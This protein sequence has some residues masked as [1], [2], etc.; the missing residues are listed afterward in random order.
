[1]K[2]PVF[3]TIAAT[4]SLIW[5]QKRDFALLSLPIIIVFSIIG[6]VTNATTWARLGNPASL[7]EYIDATQKM[8]Q[9]STP[10]WYFLA[11]LFC[12][13]F[14]IAVMILFVV[15]CHRIYL[16]PGESVLVRDAFRW[17]KLHWR[18]LLNG[19]KLM[20]VSIP[21]LF[22]MSAIVLGAAGIVIAILARAGTG[23]VDGNAPQLSQGIGGGVVFALFGLQLATGTIAGW[24]LVRFSLVFPAIAAGYPMSFRESW[25]FSA[26]NGWRLLWII[27]LTPMP[28]MLLALPVTIAVFAP[29][30]GFGLAAS[31]PVQLAENLVMQVPALLSYAIV[32]GALSLSYRRILKSR[33]QMD[34]VEE[35]FR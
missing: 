9:L 24:I 13:L 23:I 35:T 20:L 22:L 6:A 5:R 4:Y 1:M 3:R 34:G 7:Q 27:V 12:G 30:F 21:V 17:R 10:G 32:V 19:I 25:R 11:G 16:A 33:G 8:Q 29:L 15:A 2:L 31:L 28:V 18:Y 26:K 14:G